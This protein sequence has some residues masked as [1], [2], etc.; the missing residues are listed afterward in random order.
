VALGFPRRAQAGAAVGLVVAC[1]ALNAAPVFAAGSSVR[2]QEWWLR[3]LHVMQA[4]QSAQGRGITVAVLDT[5]V[6]PGQA[7]LAGA[8]DRGPDYTDSG[9]VHGGPFWGLHGTAM[10]SLI[11]GHGHGRGRSA[12]ILG[13]APNA[14]ILSVRV[15]LESGDPLLAAANIAASLPGAI[16]RGIRYAVRHHATVIALPLDPVTITAAPGAGGSAA[17]R[18]AVAYALAHR[19]VLVA[20]A[21][22]NVTGADPVNFPAAYRGVISVG[23]FNSAFIKA[24][25]SSRQPYVTLT[26]A[27][28]GVIAANGPT[29]YAQVSSTTAASAVV[30]GTVALIRAQ[31][32][33][34]SPARVTKALTESTVFR[35]HGGQRTGSGAGTMDAAAALAAA[36]RM[37]EA[38]PT[39]GSSPAS[40]A[41][42]APPPS[43]PAVHTSSGLGK[44]LLID[45]GIAVA[46]FLVLA[47]PILGYGRHRRRRARAAR[48]AEVRAAAQPRARSQPVARPARQVAATTI[49]PEEH[50]YIPAPVSAAPSTVGSPPANGAAAGAQS[51]WDSGSGS[52][53]GPPRSGPPRSGPPGSGFQGSAFTASAFPRTGRAGTSR[54]AEPSGAGAPTAT[55]GWPA[56]AGSARAGSAHAG[57]AHTGPAHT[58]PAHTGP[59]HTGPAHTGPAHTGPVHTGPAHT[60]PADAAPAHTGPAYA[61]PAHTGPAHAGPPRAGGILR[62]SAPGGGA[63]DK[64]GPAALGTAAGGI[65]GSPRTGAQR[66]PKVSGSPP[67]G[68]APE[69][70]GDVPWGRPLIPPTAGARAFPTGPAQTPAELAPEFL[71]A[72]P[73]EPP[74]TESSPWDAIAEEAWPGG[75]GSPRPGGPGAS[76]PPA[77][78][79]RGQ[80]FGSGIVGQ[81]DPGSERRD[82]GPSTGP[83]P[84]YVWDPGAST[85]SFP[86]VPPG[87]N[88]KP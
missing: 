10:A 22:D 1:L 54:A 44:T 26:A 2:S 50:G 28:D 29:G 64:S 78:P 52:P 21:G 39:P 75:P 46:V 73:P 70:A 34:L 15:T 4:Q 5:G 76:R 31:F 67:W 81:R 9:R 6:D 23:A 13:I 40:A 55:D 19:V 56:S 45:V 65:I 53:G 48:L 72:P 3:K 25:F 80:A 11:A 17:E 7:D 71:A 33:A 79:S 57:P 88:Q 61:G 77:S 41:P 60:G 42:A 66:T 35:P 24:P 8:V 59:A 85:E 27:G 36:A 16:A 14:T 47:V 12:G 83:Q 38:V 84:I 69:P 74:E 49:E 68:P 30:A 87:E 43:P 32:P 18:S 63:A 37:V 82:E 20:P 51:P 62:G 58:G 86:P